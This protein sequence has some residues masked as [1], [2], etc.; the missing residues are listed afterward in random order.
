MDDTLMLIPVNILNDM[1]TAISHISIHDIFDA[2]DI[3][4]FLYELHGG[5]HA[6]KL[7][8]IDIREIDDAL[9]CDFDDFQY[10]NEN[11]KTCVQPVSV[12]TTQYV[13]NA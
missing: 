9:N 10:E 12:K 7:F 4:D 6:K 8:G 3:L 2:Q 5:S 13:R 11:A 1:D